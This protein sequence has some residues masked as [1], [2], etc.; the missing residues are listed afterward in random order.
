MTSSVVFSLRGRAS[1]LSIWQSCNVYIWWGYRLARAF[2][3]GTSLGRNKSGGQPPPGRA[4]WYDSLRDFVDKKRKGEKVPVTAGGK[5]NRSGKE[6]AQ[7]LPPRWCYSVHVA[8]SWRVISNSKFWN[9][10]I[11][12][13]DD[14]AL[15]GQISVWRADE[16]WNWGWRNS[17]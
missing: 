3:V 14:Q 10:D 4:L 16:G 9:L 1:R 11:Y 8:F 7:P 12:D 17:R 5:L 13:P 6:A 15:L 2:K